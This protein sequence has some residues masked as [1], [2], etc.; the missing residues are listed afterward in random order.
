MMKRILIDT[1]LGI[2]CDD[3]IA[4][5]MLIN[6]EK[7]KECE[8]AS[9]TISSSRKGAAAAARAMFDWYGAACPPIGKYLGPPLP[10]DAKNI[11]ASALAEKYKKSDRAEAA[12][13]VLRRALAETRGRCTLAAIGPL[14][15]LAALLS[16][17]PDDVSPLSGVELVREK[18]EEIFVMGGCFNGMLDGEFNIEQDFFS[19]RLFTE[20]CPV[21]R[22]FVPFEAAYDILTGRDV[23]AET[24]NPVALSVRLLFEREFP[25]TRPED[26]RRRSWD[27]VT[28]LLAVRGAKNSCQIVCPGDAR[29][30]KTGAG[31][32]FLT[33]TGKDYCIKGCV[34]ELLQR[35][36]DALCVRKE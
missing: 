13:A 33:P 8:I 35:E 31:E 15:N 24:E 1:D 17:T 12:V 6:L 27:P 29:F 14:C 2:D 28:A 26:R 10:A 36:I 34:K 9:V 23:S 11:Y 19:V 3:E 7:R 32:F 25:D 30:S 20:T 4:L 18:A 5:A 16:S 21:K 22:I